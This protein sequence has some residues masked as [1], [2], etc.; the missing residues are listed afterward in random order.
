MGADTVLREMGVLESFQTFIMILGLILGRMIPILTMNPFLGGQIMPANLKIGFA[1]LV[2]ILVYQPVVAGMTQGIPQDTLPYVALLVKEVIFGA[3]IG[4]ISSLVFYAIQSAG[5]ILDQA[6]GASMAQM[7]AP[8]TG[9]QVSLFGEIKFQFAIVLF[10]LVNGH[11]FFLRAIFMSFESVPLEHIPRFLQMSNSAI[12]MLAYTTGQ[13]IAI[14]LLLAA[15]AVVAIFLTDLVFGVINRVAP[16]INVFFMAMPVKMMMGIVVILFVFG[17][18]TQQMR[19]H[20]VQML[21]D[22]QGVISIF[23]G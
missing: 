23:R 1:V 12:H 6:R 17:F 16:Q 7:L 21:R 20:F 18:L 10:F 14:G 19:E 5:R 11:H 22:V 3:C 8:Q 15:P 2:A 4:F 9:G 13:V